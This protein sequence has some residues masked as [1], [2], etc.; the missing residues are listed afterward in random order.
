MNLYRSKPT[1]VALTLAMLASVGSAIAADDEL[2]LDLDD[3]GKTKTGGVLQFDLV[4]TYMRIGSIGPYSF[5]GGNYRPG[6]WF[7]LQVEDL[8]AG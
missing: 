5:P 2:D 7:R 6:W 4:R 3:A 8:W 1:F